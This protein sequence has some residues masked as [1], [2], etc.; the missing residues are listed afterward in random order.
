MSNGTRPFVDMVTKMIRGEIPGAPIGETIGMRVV[1]V[2]P[3]FAAFEMEAD[4]RHANPMGTLHGGVLCDIADG[5]M[6]VAWASGLGE[7]ESFTTLELK[8]NFL[9]PVW[10]GKLR[11]EGRVV[12]RGKTVGLTEC[13]VRDEKGELVARASSTVMTL[14][15]DQ[16]KGR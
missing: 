10:N 4:R 1:E 9:K 12:K 5:A 16:A 8:I 6:G 13:D 14:R 15:G 11:A 3:D 7:G 2:G